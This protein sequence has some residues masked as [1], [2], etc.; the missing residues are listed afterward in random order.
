MGPA[1]PLTMQLPPPLSLLADEYMF[2]AQRFKVSNAAI[3]VLDTQ[4]FAELTGCPAECAYSVSC[5]GPG[6]A[7]RWH[8][9]ACAHMSL[10]RLVLA[11]FQTTVFQVKEGYYPTQVSPGQGC[12][13]AGSHAAQRI[14]RGPPPP[15]QRMPR[16]ASRATPF[17]ACLPAGLSGPSDEAQARS[18]HGQGECLL[19]PGAGAGRAATG[20]QQFNA[21]RPIPSRS[22]R[23]RRITPPPRS[24]RR[25]RP[26]QHCAARTGW[27]HRR[28][29]CAASTWH[30]TALVRCRRSRASRVP[31]VRQPPP[32]PPRTPS[33]DKVYPLFPEAPPPYGSGPGCTP[34]N[35]LASGTQMAIWLDEARKSSPDRAVAAKAEALLFRAWLLGFCPGGYNPLFNGDGCEHAGE[36]MG[37]LPA[38]ARCSLACC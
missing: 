37:R 12:G 17:A 25:L 33:Q 3:N 14:S 21:R 20:R 35:N 2:F 26:T 10:T 6:L 19:C 30:W 27:L 13:C 5:A 8:R 16:T 9:T 32:L 11:S 36:E 7:G 34:E 4:S 23:R 15:A 31:N 22:A 18:R 38:A 1:H 28:A 29:R 24:L